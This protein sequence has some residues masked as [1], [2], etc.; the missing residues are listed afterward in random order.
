MDEGENLELSVML[1]YKDGKE[2]ALALAHFIDAD[3]LDVQLL[4]LLV[5]DEVELAVNVETKR[6]PLQH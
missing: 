1:A 2:P 5:V 3:P 6:Q 4:A